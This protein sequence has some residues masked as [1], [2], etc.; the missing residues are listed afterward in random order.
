[1]VFLGGPRQ[2][3]K[4]TLAETLLSQTTGQYFN[5]DSSSQRKDILAEKWSD[6]KKLIVFDELHKYGKWKNWIKGVYDTQKNKHQFMVTGSARLDVYKRGGDSLLGRY[7]HWRLHPFSLTEIPKGISRQDAFARLMKV[8]GFPE[9]FLNPEEREATRWRRE[10]VTRIFR[11][12][13]RDLENIRD[14][15]AMELFID[16]LKTRVGTPVVLSNIAEDLQV[17]PK[18]LARWL[19]ILEK[20]YLIFVVRPFTEKIPR[21]IQKPPK[22][23]FFDN[24]DVEGDEGAKFENFVATHLLKKIQFLEDYTGNHYELKYIR[25]KEEREVDLAIVKNK[26]I[27]ELYEAKLSDGVI[28]KGLKYYADRLNPNLAVQI[29]GTEQKELLKGK[30]LLTSALEHFNENWFTNEP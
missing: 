14:L 9:P 18:T 15:S 30:M 4:T 1:M 27:V 28:S 16:A 20:M 19:V 24:A 23:F 21:A 5:W 29:L 25:D 2:C 17:S 13:I 11:E 7:H 12:D 22:V 6:D 8:G 3:G 26:K 10:R